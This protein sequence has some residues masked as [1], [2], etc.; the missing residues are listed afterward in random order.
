MAIVLVGTLDTKGVEYQ[1]V[2]DLLQAAGLQTLT[3]DAGSQGA[4]HFAADVKREQVFETAG[5]S[6]SAIQRAGDRGKAVEAAAAGAAL[7]VAELHRQG[8][9]DGV[10][11]L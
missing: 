9:V 7:V 3:V 5:T 2:R 11:G 10:L 4:P 6:L 1:F 8:K